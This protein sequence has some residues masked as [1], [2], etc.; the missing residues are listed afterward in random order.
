MCSPN[1][2]MVIGSLKTRLGVYQYLVE[3]AVIRIEVV[4]CL[5]LLVV[6]LTTIICIPDHHKSG[7]HALTNFIQH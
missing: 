2:F 6:H 1:N 4:P 3:F 5:H 7:K